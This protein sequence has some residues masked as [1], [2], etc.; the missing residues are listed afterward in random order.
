MV[1]FSPFYKEL[2]LDNN[3]SDAEVKKAYKK[4][5]MQWHPDKNTDNS[6]EAEKK[7]KKISEAY[8]VLSDKEK[9]IRENRNSI[10]QGRNMHTG[11]SFI[12]PD[13]LFKQFFQ[14]NVGGQS[15]INISGMGIPI[16]G[17][18]IRSSNIRI[19]NGKKIETVTEIVNGVKNEKV[20]ISDLNKPN[21]GFRIGG[22]TIH[23]INF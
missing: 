17:N 21:V 12:N 22:T 6:E 5:A 8:Q 13:D 16:G 18:V 20:I 1:D 10:P 14:M 7:F 2:Q 11:F 23:H 9:Y 4:L 15:N 3:S 19:E